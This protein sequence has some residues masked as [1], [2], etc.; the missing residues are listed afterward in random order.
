MM[1][2]ESTGDY[3]MT[4]KKARSGSGPYT[5]FHVG[6]DPR[7][8]LRPRIAEGNGTYFSSTLRID[9]SW[10]SK[11]GSYCSSYRSGNILRASLSGWAPF[12][13]KDQS[14][15]MPMNVVLAFYILIS[16]FMS[17]E[18]SNDQSVRRMSLIFSDS[19]EETPLKLYKWIHLLIYR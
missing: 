5:Y 2:W 17:L 15:T 12:L 14:R 9:P 10:G 3:S 7:S 13:V 8:H 19:R 16:T 4:I 1:I 11:G 6:C 18:R